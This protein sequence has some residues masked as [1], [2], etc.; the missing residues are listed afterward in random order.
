MSIWKGVRALQEGEREGDGRGHTVGEVLMPDMSLD[1]LASKASRGDVRA[2]AAVG[3]RMLFNEEQPSLPLA[4]TGVRKQTALQPAPA[5]LGAVGDL[6]ETSRMG[7]PF[8]PTGLEEA[9]EGNG[10]YTV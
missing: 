2:K 8:Y 9:G 5:S 1:Q 7:L 6:E 4:E 3:I 10:S